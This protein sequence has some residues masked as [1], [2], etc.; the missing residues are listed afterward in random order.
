[1]QPESQTESVQTTADCQLGL[2]MFAADIGHHAAPRGRID[3]VDHQAARRVCCLIPSLSSMIPGFMIRA[4][5]DITG[6]TTELPNC[7]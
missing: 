6:T 5:S 1:M 3:D 7:L 2:G 4:I